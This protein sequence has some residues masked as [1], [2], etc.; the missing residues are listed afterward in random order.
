MTPAEHDPIVEESHRIRENIAEA[1]GFDLKAIVAD[2]QSRQDA[3]GNL[4]VR[5]EPKRFI[6]TDSDVTPPPE[7]RL[8]RQ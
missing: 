5:R 7:S 6:E 8:T 3:H 2:M 1:H 4:L